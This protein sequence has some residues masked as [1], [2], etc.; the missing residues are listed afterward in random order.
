MELYH[1]ANLK[2]FHFIKQIALR[3]LK[4]HYDD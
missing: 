1:R 3:K 4:N 2:C